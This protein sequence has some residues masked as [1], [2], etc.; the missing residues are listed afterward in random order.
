MEKCPN[1]PNRDTKGQTL[2]S[3]GLNKMMT[4]HLFSQEGGRKAVARYIIKDEV[5]FRVVEKEG[6]EDLLKYFQPKFKMPSRP[7]ISTDCYIIYKEEKEALKD[8][9][10]RNNFRMCFTTDCWTSLQNKC[11]MCLT[12]HWIDDDWILQKRILNF[13]E[14]ED[15]KGATIAKTLEDCIF[16]WGIDKVFSITV[17]NA[18]ANDSALAILKKRRKLKLVDR[19]SVV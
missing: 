15:H 16:N 7:T 17:D 13:C 14:I 8:Y 4:H 9:F 10:K 12:A 5:P 19:K 3:S 18:S 1:N 2:L 6:L 11:F